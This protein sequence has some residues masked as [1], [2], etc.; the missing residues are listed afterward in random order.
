MPN[1]CRTRAEIWH[2]VATDVHKELR[3]RWQT[4]RE[5][6]GAYVASSISDDKKTAAAVYAMSSNSL[7]R[8]SFEEQVAARYGCTELVPVQDRAMFLSEYVFGD[9][10]T[11]PRSH[12]SGWSFQMLTR[13]SPD[14]AAEY[15]AR[16]KT[17]FDYTPSAASSGVRA[18]INNQPE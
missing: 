18:A 13:Q 5:Q 7:L 16:A 15:R 2:G 9:T 17:E 12:I 6:L 3:D 11:R 4:Q 1:T 14:I 10:S 8:L